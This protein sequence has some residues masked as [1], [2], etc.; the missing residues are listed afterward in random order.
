MESSFL[1]SVYIYNIL[2]WCSNN[3]GCLVNQISLSILTVIG[4][5]STIPQ[6]IY[7]QFRIFFILLHLVA[8]WVKYWPSP[9]FHSFESFRCILWP[10]LLSQENPLIYFV[11]IFLLLIKKNR[12]W[13]CIP[14]LWKHMMVEKQMESSEQALHS[15]F[16][17]KYARSFLLLWH[18]KLMKLVNLCELA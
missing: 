11:E 10:I 9:I 15:A 8:C 1:C 4:V 18:E 3:P 16:D 6:E 13:I 12:N 5:F 2:C 17:D 14:A 7:L